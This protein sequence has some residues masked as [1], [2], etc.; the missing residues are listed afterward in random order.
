MLGMLLIED[1][2]VTVSITCNS[3]LTID[4]YKVECM[5]MCSTLAAF[6]SAT[7]LYSQC[8]VYS[9]SCTLSL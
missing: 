5:I 8:T 1:R 3:V 6:V 9:L 2:L 4:V 7:E